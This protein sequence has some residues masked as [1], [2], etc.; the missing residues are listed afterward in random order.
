LKKVQK[1][2]KKLSYTE[3]RTFKNKEK[4][5][6]KKHYAIL[7]SLM[8]V[9][10]FLYT[11]NDTII[12]GKDFRFPLFS[13]YFP[14]IIGFMILF[15]YR[16]EFLIIKLLSEKNNWIKLLMVVFY[17]IEGLL[18]SFLALAYPSQFILTQINQKISSSNPIEIVQCDIANFFDKRRSSTVDFKYGNNWEQIRISHA[19]MKLYINEDPNNFTLE[20]TVKKGIWN[21]YVVQKF[22]IHTKQKSL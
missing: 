3:K 14:L 18:V 11:I 12:I 21:T 13:I 20:L 9:Y 16:K 4:K 7:I 5:L 6:E 17:F 8:L 15:F 22:E 19:K 2:N 1:M 10:I